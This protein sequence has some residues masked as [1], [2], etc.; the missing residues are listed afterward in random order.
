M[1]LA[2]GDRARIV[3]SVTE[4]L[5]AKYGDASGDKNPIHSGDLKIA[6]GLVALGLISRVISEKLP[7]P[8]SVIARQEIDFTAPVLVDDRL[9]IAVIV[10]EIQ[11]RKVWLAIEGKTNGQDRVLNGFCLVLTP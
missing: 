8:G 11:G 5:I 7:G 4:D 3:I 6:H 10:D 1:N 9:A 2:V